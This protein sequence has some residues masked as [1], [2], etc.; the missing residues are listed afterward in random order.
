VEHEKS[1]HT[2][3]GRDVLLGLRYMGLLGSNIFMGFF[4]AGTLGRV[5]YPYPCPR[6]KFYTRTLTRG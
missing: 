2:N 3:G 1:V 4:S 5:S 6:V